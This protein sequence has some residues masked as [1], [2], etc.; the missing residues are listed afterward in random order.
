MSVKI[1]KKDRV[2]KSKHSS[3]SFFF[4][5]EDDSVHSSL[6]NG[7]LKGE[8]IENKRSQDNQKTEFREQTLGR[9]E[10]VPFQQIPLLQ[11]QR[12]ST[13]W[14]GLDVRV[15]LPCAAQRQPSPSI[16]GLQNPWALVHISCTLLT[17]RNPDTCGTLSQEID[18]SL[19]FLISVPQEGIW[20]RWTE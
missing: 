5:A 2:R 6:L 7:N 9:A 8:G 10:P 17:S 1:L 11:L 3:V 18:L 16:A 4:Q 13:G 19:S 12:G 15:F 20:R 14:Q